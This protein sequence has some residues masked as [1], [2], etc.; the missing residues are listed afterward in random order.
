MAIFT[1]QQVASHCQVDDC[2]VILNSKIY[3]ISD[4]LEEDS[5]P[6][7]FTVL[8]DYF[9]K[10]ISNIFFKNH[11]EQEFQLLSFYEIGLLDIN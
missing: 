4:Y 11:S 8:V 6:G 7:G 9:G 10:D 5:H 2:W 1:K 3:D